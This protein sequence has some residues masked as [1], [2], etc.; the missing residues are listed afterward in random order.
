LN[1]NSNY[2]EEWNQLPRHERRKLIKELRRNE[3]KRRE[4]LRGVFMFFVFLAVFLMIVLGV[5]FFGRDKENNVEVQMVDKKALAEKVEEFPIEGRDHVGSGVEVSYKTNPPT[6]GSHLAKEADW[7]VYDE[8]LDDRAV[9]HSIEHG[10][11]WI[12]YKDISDEE[13]AVLEKIG[14]ENPDRVIVSPRSKN[15]DKVVVVSWGRM[16]RL[17][18]ANELLIGQYMEKYVND[19]PEKMVR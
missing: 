19:S 9:V 7:G 11:F 14:N 3:K 4:S 10:G 6:S 12:S 1:I 13:I 16:M 15:D 5:W 2:P 17:D 18:E 8:E